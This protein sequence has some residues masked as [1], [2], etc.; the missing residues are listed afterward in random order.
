MK[1][2]SIAGRGVLLDYYAYSQ[3]ARRK[4]GLINCVHSITYQDLVDCAKYQGTEI[5][6]GDLLFV[7]SGFWVGYKH[8]TEEEKTAWGAAAPRDCKAVGVEA[9]RAMARWLWE[10]GIAACAGDA[11]AWEKVPSWEWPESAGLE[12]LSLHE[13]MLGGW[14]MPIG[15]ISSSP[16]RVGRVRCANSLHRGVV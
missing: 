4:Y 13:I 12:G 1:R 14:G 10:S 5:R 6:E 15:A 7:R 8:L 3:H 9:T 11:P 2:G 16:T